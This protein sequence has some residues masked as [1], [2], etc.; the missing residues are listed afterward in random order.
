MS[1]AQFRRMA[2]LESRASAYLQHNHML[3]DEG[4]DAYQRGNGVASQPGGKRF[5]P[6]TLKPW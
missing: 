5:A 1:G 3:Q 6:N 2:R 4:Q